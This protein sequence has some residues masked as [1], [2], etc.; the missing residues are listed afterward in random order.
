MSYVQRLQT[1]KSF[2][3]SCKNHSLP[4][5]LQSHTLSWHTQ[6]KPLII[7]LGMLTSSDVESMISEVTQMQAL[8][9]PNVM[10]LVGVC[11]DAS[12]GPSIIMPYMANGSLLSYLKKERAS[13]YLEFDADEDAIISVRRLLL[14]MC[15]QIALGMQYLSDQKIVHRDLAARNCMYV[16]NHLF[17][18]GS[19][20]GLTN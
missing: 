10:S 16:T 5:L 19:S 11:V 12:Q 9:H 15:Y 7:S 17:L 2:A 6:C 4:L 18:I 13:L 20:L 1:L 3:A 14:R 8:S